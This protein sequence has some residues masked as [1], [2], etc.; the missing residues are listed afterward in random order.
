MVSI[1]DHSACVILFS[2][3]TAQIG[4][5]IGGQFNSYYINKIG[6]VWTG[7]IFSILH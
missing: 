5:L 1:I 2:C 6:E 7:N 4:D 3:N